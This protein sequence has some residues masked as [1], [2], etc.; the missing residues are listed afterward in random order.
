MLVGAVVVVVTGA[1]VD[2]KKGKM[3]YRKIKAA[4]IMG[5]KLL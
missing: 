3:K 1:G 5:S 4:M 2:E